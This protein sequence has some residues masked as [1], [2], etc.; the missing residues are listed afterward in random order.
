MLI[1]RAVSAE[2]T[3]V[4]G[5]DGPWAGRYS[6]DP[7]EQEEWHNAQRQFPLEI[8]SLIGIPENTRKIRHGKERLRFFHEKT[9]DDRNCFG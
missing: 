7:Y 1:S 3:A 5:A 6:R 8:A 9:C 4:N 2:L